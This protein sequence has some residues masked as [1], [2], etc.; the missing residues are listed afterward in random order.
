MKIKK[1]VLFW[2]AI[3]NVKYINRLLF[4]IFSKYRVEINGKV[5]NFNHYCMS[6][7]LITFNVI[8]IY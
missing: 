5:Y 7:S 8:I 4:V 6:W 2:Y 1:Y 3:S